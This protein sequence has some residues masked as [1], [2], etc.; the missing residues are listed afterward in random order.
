MTELAEAPTGERDRAIERIPHWIGGKRV[1]GTSGR[2]GP[3]YDP[4][5]GVQTGAVDLASTAE[6]AT[7]VRERRRGLR[8]V[9]GDVALE[10]GRPLLRDPRA[11]PRQA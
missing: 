2:T 1:E 6:V 5:L 10:A 11:L 7:A 9:A 4:A 8:V 3:V